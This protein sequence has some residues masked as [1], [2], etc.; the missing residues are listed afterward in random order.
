MYK[1]NVGLVDVATDVKT[2][3][4]SVYGAT[5]PQFKSVS[6]LKFTKYNN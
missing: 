2:Y 5:S 1:D 4:K 6:S 3:I